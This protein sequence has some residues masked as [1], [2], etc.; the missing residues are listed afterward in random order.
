[1]WIVQ[2]ID[3]AEPRVY[4]KNA[5]LDSL[6]E[7]SLANE[8]RRRSFPGADFNDVARLKSSQNA[9]DLRKSTVSRF[10]QI[11]RKDIRNPL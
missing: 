6:R 2:V 8:R 3:V 1:M 9:C 11:E 5:W 4:A 10:L 7:Q